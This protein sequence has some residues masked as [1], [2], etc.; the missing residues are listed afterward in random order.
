MIDCPRYIEAFLLYIQNE[1]VISYWNKFQEDWD[2]VGKNPFANSGNVEGFNN[3]TFEVHAYDWVNE[4]QPY[5]F[6]YKDIEISWY[7]YFGR[8]MT[9]NNEV[10]PTEAIEM[11]NNCVD[12][13]SR[14][15]NNKVG[16]K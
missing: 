7:K 13:L 15:W 10:T 8:G 16:K 12:S 2:E 11:F 3:G 1:M 9:M 5:N 4:D 14:S 6:K